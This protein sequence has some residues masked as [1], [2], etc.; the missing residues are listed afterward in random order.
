MFPINSNPPPPGL[1]P[2]TP[3]TDSPSEDVPS[4]GFNGQSLSFSHPSAPPPLS[5]LPPR[6]SSDQSQLIVTPNDAVPSQ[7]QAPLH[8]SSAGDLSVHDEPL[9]ID[10]T[11]SN[12]P[13]ARNSHSSES[14]PT[15]GYFEGVVGLKQDGTAMVDRQHSNGSPYSRYIPPP[16]QSHHPHPYRRGP[17]GPGAPG[18]PLSPAK[19]TD[20][21]PVFAMPFAPQQGYPA[22]H[23]GMLAPL[24]DHAPKMEKQGSHPAD[25]ESQ[26][27]QRW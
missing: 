18:A 27:W 13:S 5:S 19:A 12:G 2:P 4:Q 26:S 20:G 3:P 16:V 21:K 9:V 14:T 15:G 7:Q 1:S 8:R 25:G 17:G 24:G 22:S 11:L 6:Q 23:D 10:P